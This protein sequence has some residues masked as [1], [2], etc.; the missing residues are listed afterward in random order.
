ML[1]AVE[2]K[3]PGTEQQGHC[4]FSLSFKKSTVMR[5]VGSAFLKKAQTFLFNTAFSLVCDIISPALG[6]KLEA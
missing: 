6:L 5:C 3:A 4:L 2:L 1:P